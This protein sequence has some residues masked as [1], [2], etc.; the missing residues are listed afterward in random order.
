VDIPEGLTW[1]VGHSAV[2]PYIANK[3]AKHS[4]GTAISADLVVFLVIKHFKMCLNGSAYNHLN[5]R[6]LLLP[7]CYSV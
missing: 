1:T 6:F 4:S 5:A 3:S 7:D 2:L